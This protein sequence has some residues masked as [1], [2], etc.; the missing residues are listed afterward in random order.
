[1][2]TTLQKL[3][4][5]LSTVRL[6]FNSGTTTGIQ[7]FG[8]IDLGTIATPVDATGRLQTPYDP[9]PVRVSFRLL[10]RGANEEAM[11]TYAQQIATELMTPGPYKVQTTAMAAPLY[12]DAVGSSISGLLRGQADAIYNL[13]QQLSSPEGFPVEL[14]RLPYLYSAKLRSVVNLLT[15]ATLVKATTT[16][17]R[18]DLWTWDSTT[19]ISAETMDWTNQAY[20]FSI[21]TTGARNLQQTTP[22][23]S[24]TG[25]LNY[26]A[27]VYAKA[28][29]GGIAR[30]TTAWQGKNNA[31]TNQ[32]SEVTS[33]Q[34]TLTTD[35]QRIEAS[36][37]ANASATKALVSL[38]F[39]NVSATAVTVY[40]RRGQF[41]Q[42]STATTFRT[43]TET[44]SNDPAAAMG[45]IMPVWVDGNARTRAILT[46][47]PES[48]A[49]I[50][51]ARISRRSYGNLTEFA[52]SIHFTQAES[53]TAGTN[54]TLG[55]ADAAASGTTARI[56]NGAGGTD[57]WAK[58]LRWQVSPGDKTAV[59]GSYRVYARIKATAA[60]ISGNP[61]LYWLQLRWSAGNTDPVS[62]SNEVV[63]I[64][65]TDISAD[66]WNRVDLGSVFVERGV[67]TT[68]GLTLELWAKREDSES[69]NILVDHVALMPQGPTA[70]Q[71]Q[72][73]ALIISTRGWR[74][75]DGS[76]PEHWN[77]SDLVT[78]TSAS[79][80]VSGGKVD[81]DSIVLDTA[82]EAAGTPPVG[83]FTVATGR[84]TWTANVALSHKP[85]SGTGP[86]E[87]A[88]FRV[89]NITDSTEV[90]KTLTIRSKLARIRKQARTD[91]AVSSSAKAYQAQIVNS[92]VN[93]T[94]N[95]EVV[96]VLSMNHSY[97]RA[98]T[99]ASALLASG[100]YGLVSGRP[101][102][103]VTTGGV[104]VEP[105]RVQGP[106][107]DLNPGL[108]L[109][110]FDWGDIP[111][112]GYEQADAREPLPLNVYNRACTVA[113]DFFPRW[114]T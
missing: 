55:V 85:N 10:L 35:W 3:E 34:T 106:W 63:P 20:S 62:F 82:G 102:A 32:G 64:D 7:V 39:G 98:I 101:I 18:P 2:T 51:Q 42:A 103:Q 41:E 69:G 88:E 73:Q 9:D 96:R 87:I 66:Q 111:G 81:G 58:R 53:M 70:T 105:L 50:V 6:D 33:T 28:S 76:N 16:P 8:D 112:V 113:L 72:D 43:G 36:G 75:P 23:S 78:P 68:Y 108:N 83:G 38:R 79:S 89:R 84:H 31:G 56:W 47:T 91:I 86:D 54:T 40:L 57:A 49:S 61:A 5:D 45:R 27:S 12:M 65:L 100:E 92:G 59:E 11:R 97:L 25:S 109:L 60:L 110:I 4:T 44:V 99:N 48:G 107:L 94:A 80:T 26:D 21:A 67:S 17:N 37:V 114:T 71:A 90:V 29:A 24:M 13:T 22:N 14:V 95:N 74:D 19:N 1:M 77:G 15:N 104:A 52:N 46:M 30:L 93:P